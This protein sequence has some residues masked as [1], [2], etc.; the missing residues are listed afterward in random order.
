MWLLKKWLN[1]KRKMSNKRV[2]GLLGNGISHSFSPV[3]FNKMFERE[4]INA[5]YRLFDFDDIQEFYRFLAAN[6]EIEGFN[7]TI[8]FKRKIIKG[9]KEVD[10]VAA[11]AGAVNTVKVTNKGLIGFNTDVVGFELSL[12]SLLKNR[13]G[14]KA[15]VLGTGGASKAVQLVLNRLNISFVLVSRTKKE[16]VLTYDD[17]TP[18]IITNYCLII[19]T[20]PLGMFPQTALCPPI[21]YRFISTRHILFDLIYNPEETLFLKKGK[22][23]GAL[24]KNGLEMLHLQAE[25]SWKIWNSR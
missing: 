19:N 17:L 7:V 24:V 3:F 25:A 9:L 1:Q 22:A 2:F 11:Q 5:E 14:L 16:K 10:V 4:R 21:P 6:S 20:T 15:L 23:N 18:E 12:V 13:S 8:P